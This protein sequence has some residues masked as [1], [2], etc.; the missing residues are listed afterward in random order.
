MVVNLTHFYNKETQSLNLEST[1]DLFKNV[2]VYNSLGQEVINEKLSQNA[3]IIDMS[4]LN[5]GIYTV[6]L[7]LGNAVKTVKVFKQYEHCF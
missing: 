2:S 5:N 3:E 6:Q 7:N 1:N 4:V